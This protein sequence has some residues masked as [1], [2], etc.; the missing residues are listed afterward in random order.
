MRGSTQQPKDKY[1]PLFTLD[2]QIPCLACLPIQIL[3]QNLNL[4]HSEIR[5][6]IIRK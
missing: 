5:A 6:Q 4:Q 2:P 1:S 3:P